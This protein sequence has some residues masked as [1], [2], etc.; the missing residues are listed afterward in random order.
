[1]WDNRDKGDERYTERGG[2]R[3]LRPE[4]VTSDLT[5]RRIFL[6]LRVLVI[7]YVAYLL[8]FH[9]NGAWGI[10]KLKMEERALN[11]RIAE[12]EEQIAATEAEIELLETDEFTWEKVA[13]ERYGMVR[14][15]EIVLRFD[16]LE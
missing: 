14:E 1:M 3:F 8:V 9:D 16:D 15:G 12:L 7:G 11:A 13:R 2:N 4:T 6:V 5:R 10:L